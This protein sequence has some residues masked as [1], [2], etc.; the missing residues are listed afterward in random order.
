MD[1]SH[2]WRDKAA[3]AGT[4]SGPR[5]FGAGVQAGDRLDAG[6]AE[7]LYRFRFREPSS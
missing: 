4:N 2:R 1:I 3:A 7:Y 6:I 5:S